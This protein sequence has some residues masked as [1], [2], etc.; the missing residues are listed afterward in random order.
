MMDIKK[1]KD[2]KNIKVT[3][4]DEQISVYELARWMS[5]MEALDVV[6]RNAE[7]MKID[8]NKYNQWVKPLAFQKYINER[9]YGMCAD[10]LM[11]EKTEE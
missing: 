3:L 7:R 5:L 11:N 1:L 6:T 10:V 9:T 2:S 8:L 4:K